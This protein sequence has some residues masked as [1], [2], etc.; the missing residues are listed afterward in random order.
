MVIRRFDDDDT[1]IPY[2]YEIGHWM[3]N[4]NWNALLR[5]KVIN[6]DVESVVSRATRDLHVLNGG[7]G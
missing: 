7:N 6:G 5:Y 3:P 1:E 4:G 2:M